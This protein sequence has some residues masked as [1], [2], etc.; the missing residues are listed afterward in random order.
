[1]VDDTTT[2]EVKDDTWR[3]LDIRKER[4]E[5]FDDVIRRM[6]GEVGPDVGAI[7]TD[8]NIR[9]SDFEHAPGTDEDC[10]HYNIVAGETCGEPAEWRQV[11][12]YGEDDDDGDVMH[13][14]DDHGPRNDE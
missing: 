11:V 14:C 7:K 1:M 8:A 9:G 3:A 5:S 2:I 4:G 10:V 13:F 6:V 12:F